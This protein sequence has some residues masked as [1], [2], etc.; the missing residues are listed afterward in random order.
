MRTW[1][2]GPAYDYKLIQE[3]QRTSFNKPMLTDYSGCLE[4]RVETLIWSYLWALWERLPVLSGE[5]FHENRMGKCCHRHHVFPKQGTLC[6]NNCYAGSILENVNEI[7]T[8]G[9]GSRKFQIPVRFCLWSQ[10]WIL[11][12]ICYPD[13]G[14]K[15]RITV[16]PL[17]AIGCWCWEW[18]YGWWLLSCI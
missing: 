10:K 11:Q 6:R 9:S 8:E 15:V 17:R 4:K 2:T 1:H 16:L 5:V 18:N 14:Q 13:S 7:T 12:C 3:S